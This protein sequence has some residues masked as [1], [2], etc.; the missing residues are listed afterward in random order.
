M[1]FYQQPARRFMKRRNLTCV[2][3]LLFTSLARAGASDGKLDIYFIDVEGG[4]STLIVTPTNESVLV[5]TGNPG[6]RDSKRIFEAAKLA[7]LSQ[8]DHLIITH[9]H[10]DHFGGAADL[11]KLIPFKE[12][13]DNA[14]ENPSRD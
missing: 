10:G 1:I 12:I 5:D 13:Y 7:E 9:Y 2:L 14:D 6:E 11:V 3:V 4:A 8:I